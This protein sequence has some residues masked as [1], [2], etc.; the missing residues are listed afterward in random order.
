[1]DCGK[2]QLTILDTRST[3]FDVLPC[4][5]L[6]CGVICQCEMW[7][8]PSHKM[9]DQWYAQLTSPLSNLRVLAR[10]KS[11]QTLKHDRDETEHETTKNIVCAKEISLCR[12][13]VIHV[14]NNTPWDLQLEIPTLVMQ[15][16]YIFNFGKRIIAWIKK[17]PLASYSEVTS[18]EDVRPL[19]LLLKQ[20]GIIMRHSIAPTVSSSKVLQEMISGAHT[21]V[22]DL[23]AFRAS[24]HASPQNLHVQ[25][26]EFVCKLRSFSG[27]FA[28]LYEKL[29][30]FIDGCDFVEG[31]APC[32]A[33]KID[34]FPHQAE[35]ISC[36]MPTDVNTG[37]VA[38][39]SSMQVNTSTQ[40][41]IE[42]QEPDHHASCVYR[43]TD[44]VSG[45]QCRVTLHWEISADRDAGTVRAW[46]NHDTAKLELN[47]VCTTEMH[48]K[49]S[50]S[51]T[52]HI[53]LPGREGAGAGSLH[54]TK[55]NHFAS[56][57]DRSIAAAKKKES[58]STD[59]LMNFVPGAPVLHY[60]E[61]PGKIWTQWAPAVDDEM[62]A[63]TYVFEYCRLLETEADLALHEANKN[64]L[65]AH[66][67]RRHGKRQSK[68][69]GSAIDD[70]Q[71]IA[72][73]VGSYTM[74]T[75]VDAPAAQLR[76]RTQSAFLTT[77]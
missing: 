45:Q 24:L 26:T 44:V 1:M 54:E 39:F 25:Q 38:V 66:F 70:G 67:L 17:A 48:S 62:G 29:Q 23:E 72:V 69:D 35:Q 7:F 59:G 40:H 63:F 68:L 16:R 43:C 13:A 37:K 11:L 30:R 56:W 6:T 58:D 4:S 76:V 61:V 52:F 20:I 3:Y 65:D 10:Q 31:W 74:C 22:R 2:R 46:S 55:V 32:L 75:L 73:P 34:A 51:F 36:Q 50:A 15:M 5:S 42:T 60:T 64:E 33:T 12:I 8:R 28:R 49:S 21:C 9:L 19:H 18:S 57:L 71:W 14:I 53:S 47:V 41:A 77:A 27:K